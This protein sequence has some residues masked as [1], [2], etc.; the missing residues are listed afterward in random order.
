MLLL[1]PGVE[2][3]ISQAWNPLLPLCNYFIPAHCKCWGFLIPTVGGL[4]WWCF[5]PAL[6]PVLT[7]FPSALAMASGSC[8]DSQPI[9]RPQ[10]CCALA[11]I[12]S[13]LP[14]STLSLPA[15]PQLTCGTRT[16]ARHPYHDMSPCIFKRFPICF[17]LGGNKESSPLF[18]CRKLPILG[19]TS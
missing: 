2:G 9:V 16:G 15:Q 10:G 14:S 18:S 19:K 3:L 8:P 1:R 12:C 13:H 17:V 4:G 5:S 6:L 11:G 7:C